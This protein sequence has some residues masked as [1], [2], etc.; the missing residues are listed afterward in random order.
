MRIMRQ[1]FQVPDE[2][3]VRFTLGP[4]AVQSLLEAHVHAGLQEFRAHLGGPLAIMVPGGTGRAVE[5][6]G[7]DQDAIAEA[8]GGLARVQA[9]WEEGDWRWAS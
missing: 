5:V 3:E 4:A 1:A 7:R 9:A 2:Y 8:T 6:H